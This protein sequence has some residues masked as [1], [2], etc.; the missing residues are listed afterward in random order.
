VAR[1]LRWT[2]FFGDLAVLFALLDWLKY[3]FHLGRYSRVSLTRLGAFRAT[4]ELYSSFAAKTEVGD[5]LFVHSMRSFVG[6]TIMYLTHGP[7]SHVGTISAPATVYE[8]ISKGIGEYPLKKYFDGKHYLLLLRLPVTPDQKEKV[9]AYVQ[10]EKGKPYGYRKVLRL[11]M[12]T[13]CNEHPDYRFTFTLDTLISLSVFAIVPSKILRIAVAVIA[14]AYLVVLG[15]NSVLRLR[16]ALRLYRDY[17]E[18][19][20]PRSHLP[21]NSSPNRLYRML[22]RQSGS[23][24]LSQ[25]RG[26]RTGSTLEG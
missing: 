1:E 18:Y 19:A 10:A 8:A 3:E 20:S 15:V 23:G 17:L 13:L 5:Q 11:L 14:A 21:I 4:P 16:S 6:W 7:W 22:T 2:I 26:D 25:Q 24:I 12:L 9:V